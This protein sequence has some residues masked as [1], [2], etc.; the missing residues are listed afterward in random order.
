[1]LEVTL[2]PLQIC[3]IP[4][5]VVLS[6]GPEIKKKKCGELPQLAIECTKSPP[7]YIT[8][9]A[10]RGSG[11]RTA[12]VQS[13]TP[14]RMI[15]TLRSP[16]SR[17]VTR[18]RPTPALSPAFASRPFEPALNLLPLSDAKIKINS[19]GSLRRRPSSRPSATSS[20]SRTSAS[21]RSPPPSTSSASSTAPTSATP[22]SSTTPRATTCS[23]RSA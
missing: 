6:W 2:P 15:S 9:A 23:P 21:S 12:P 18:P 11:P 10:N 5:P 22:R 17:F 14:S 8:Y 16:I 20:G 1:M 7:N 13:W 3:P 19:S 4:G